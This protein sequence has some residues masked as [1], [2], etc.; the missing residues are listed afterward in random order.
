MIP[1]NDPQPPV[2]Q[3]SSG[4]VSA[5]YITENRDMLNAMTAVRDSVK[6]MSTLFRLSLDAEKKASIPLEALDKNLRSVFDKLKVERRPDER[7]VLERQVRELTKE[8][9]A[10]IR[11]A[12][13][14]GKDVG[15]TIRLEEDID[16]YFEKMKD[17]SKKPSPMA[18]GVGYVKTAQ[19]LYKDPM[20]L[21]SKELL[22]LGPEVWLVVAAVTALAQ[23]F[24]Y[25]QG[26]AVESLGNT[27][28]LTTAGGLMNTSVDTSIKMTAA[29]KTA[30]MGSADTAKAMATFIKG[31]GVSTRQMT[32][33]IP[34][35]AAGTIAY[36]PERQAAGTIAYS[37]ERQA[38][39][40]IHTATAMQRIS[41]AGHFL[42]LSVEEVGSTMATAASRFHVTSRN[43]ENTFWILAKTSMNTGIQF[44]AVADMI[45]VAGEKLRWAG[46]GAESFIK[47]A[48]SISAVTAQMMDLSR[49]SERWKGFS[50]G[51]F[52]QMTKTFFDL[53]QNM[54]PEQ[55]IGLTYKGKGPMTMPQL[56]DQISD[57]WSTGTMEG[58]REAVLSWKDKF[59][60]KGLNEQQM[61]TMIGSQAPQFKG[62]G[63]M[64]AKMVEVLSVSQDVFTAA[65]R[66]A[67]G[68]DMSTYLRNISMSGVTLDPKSVQ[69]LAQAQAFAADP[70][71]AILHKLDQ[72]FSTFTAV[73]NVITHGAIKVTGGT[74]EQYKKLP[75]LGQQEWR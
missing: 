50:A 46:A 35:T 15:G 62:L 4:D 32:E 30:Y 37:P 9:S 34:V 72:I 19:S 47:T 12:I 26:L 58:M 36:S 69:E 52:E 51:E 24:K 65:T 75:L 40:L 57:F 71:K 13:V 45:G 5:T 66:G 42:G 3:S 67:G 17:E 25:Y 28:L 16:R 74:G 18:E 55:Y 63:P 20:A 27:K 49:S 14:S 41:V 2:T 10:G 21:F 48:D 56:A 59:K 8:M 29:L 64:A 23:A 70:L 7:G 11:A 31:Y 53:W 6:D 44:G 33:A 68:K 54:Q 61:Y 73:A 22:A 38:A 60:D 43:L 39:T 1:T